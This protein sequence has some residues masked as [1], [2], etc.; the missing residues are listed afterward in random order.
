MLL[1]ATQN[2]LIRAHIDATPALAAHPITPDGSAAIADA[3]NALSVPAFHVW[4]TSVS[5]AEIMAG[6]FRWADV[7]ALTVG[8][9]RIW[10]WMTRLGEIKP[11]IATVRTG[12]ADCWGAGSVNETRIL[13]ACRRRASVVERVLATGLGSTS[14]PATMGSEGPISYQEVLSI[15]GG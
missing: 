8:K 13:A 15:R 12:I 14:E 4:K 6:N 2:D 10:D 11:A 3:L 1:T 9:A 7:D 5:I